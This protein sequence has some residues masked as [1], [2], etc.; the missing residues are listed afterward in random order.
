MFRRFDS[1]LTRLLMAQVGLLVAA[2]FIFGW[3]LVAERSGVQVHLYASFWARQVLASA[4]LPSSGATSPGHVNAET[5]RYD[6]LPPGFKPSILSIPN[7][8]DFIDEMARYGVT[9]DDVRLDRSQGE[10]KLWLHIVL[11]GHAPFWLH[12]RSPNARPHWSRAV[13][14]GIGLLC[15]LIAAV[16]WRFTRRVT[17]PLQALRLH[18]QAHARQGIQPSEVLLPLN[19]GQ[20]P[21]ELIAIDTAYRQLAER[22]AR[23]ERE[24][25]LLLAGVSHDLRSPLSRI[26]LA[27]EMLPESADNA[28][29]VASIT[30]NVD[31]AD[32]LTA[33]FLA[34]IRTGTVA[35]DQTVD[36][37][38]VARQAVSGFERPLHEL[39][40]HAPDSMVM[41]QAHNLLLERLVTNLVD[42]ALKHGRTPVRVA[43]QWQGDAVVLTVTDAGPGLPEGETSRLLE[44]FARGDASRG[45]PGF[46]LG[47]AISQ[48]IVV[49]LQ[50]E[51]S[52]QR[53][54]GGHQ[55]KARLPLRR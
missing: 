35:L 52:F 32:Q 39:D 30:R 19:A 18:M 33:S 29:G 14:Y 55:V 45:V 44:A 15:L 53:V 31:Q 34:F 17:R 1:L 8:V 47:L 16:S 10:G 40:V 51:L 26:R 41:H 54:D 28:A 38:T 36:V 50:G 7:V 43:L 42:N 4:E 46:G 37:A 25:A 12:S 27:A 3:L 11:D 20:A 21:P 24:R 13:F 49:R 22:L 5:D 2:M 9:V 6:T 23:N 48:Q